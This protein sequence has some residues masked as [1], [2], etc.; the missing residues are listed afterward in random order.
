MIEMEY[1]LGQGV[2]RASFQISLFREGKRAFRYACS[3]P[4]I[5]LLESL[6]FHYYFIII[7]VIV[8][9]VILILF[10]FILLS[11]F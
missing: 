2:K 6:L 1:P 7:P 4:S 5:R 3:P 8:F 10:V 9:V 11:Y